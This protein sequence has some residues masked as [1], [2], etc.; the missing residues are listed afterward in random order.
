MTRD[1]HPLLLDLLSAH[2][3]AADYGSGLDPRLLELLCDRHARHPGVTRLPLPIRHDG[4]V[5][6]VVTTTTRQGIADVR[7]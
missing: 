2:A 3:M 1:A 4:P 7:R 5:S 6:A